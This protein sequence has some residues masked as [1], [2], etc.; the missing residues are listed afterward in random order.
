MEEIKDYQL[1][2]MDIE[3]AIVDIN[4]QIV[5]Y[6]Q[7]MYEEGVSEDEAAFLGHFLAG[8]YDELERHNEMLDQF[9]DKTPVDEFKGYVEAKQQAKEPVVKDVKD[10]DYMGR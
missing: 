6:E 8:L 7:R 5:E 10:S 3:S 9:E 1:D 4:A 2:K